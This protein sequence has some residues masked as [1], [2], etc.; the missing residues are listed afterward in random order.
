MHKSHANRGGI[1]FP[2]LLLENR[3]LKKLN[4]TPCTIC[5]FMCYKAREVGHMQGLNLDIF[6]F[7]AFIVLFSI[8]LSYQQS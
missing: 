3:H 1:F 5:V 7:N 4:E 8:N 6:K 2:V